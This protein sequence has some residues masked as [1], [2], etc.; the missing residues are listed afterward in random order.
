MAMCSFMC[1]VFWFLGSHTT[2]SQEATSKFPVPSVSPTICLLTELLYVYLHYKQHMLPG[3][4]VAIAIAFVP[5]GV[6]PLGVMIEGVEA[7]GVPC[8][9]P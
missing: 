4:G 7:C 5:V 1:A 6:T 3:V 9:V 2:T 8:G